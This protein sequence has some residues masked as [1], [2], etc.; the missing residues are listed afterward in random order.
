MMKI[1]EISFTGGGN[2][3]TQRN[4]PEFVL[5]T[6]VKKYVHRGKQFLFRFGNEKDSLLTKRKNIAPGVS[7][8][9]PLRCPKKVRCQ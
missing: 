8:D 6:Y 4:P 5:T 3:S 9:P 7:N 2:P 1:Q